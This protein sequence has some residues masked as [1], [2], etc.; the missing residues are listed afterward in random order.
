M[1]ALDSKVEKVFKKIL[2]DSNCAEDFLRQ[3]TMDEMYE[4]F[5]KMDSSISKEEFDE[6]ILDVLKN[7]EKIFNQEI[8]YEELK[9]VAG[10]NIGTRAVSGMLSVLALVPASGSFMAKTP[11]SNVGAHKPSSGIVSKIKS[12]ASYAAEAAKSGFVKTARWI[13]NN[14]KKSIAIAGSIAGIVLVGGIYKYRSSKL[15]EEK[16]KAET[17]RRAKEKAEAERKIQERL[18]AEEV[19]RKKQAEAEET[20]KAQQEADSKKREKAAVTP[21]A[22]SVDA[23]PAEQPK[24]LP[25]PPPKPLPVPPPKPLPVPPSKPLPVPPSKPLPMPEAAQSAE[26]LTSQA[27]YLS[28]EAKQVVG[29]KEKLQDQIRNSGEPTHKIKDAA[30]KVARDTREREERL[31]QLEV[32]AEKLMEEIK[33][34][35]AKNPRLSPG[36]SDVLKNL[37]DIFS[38]P[39]I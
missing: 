33:G 23:K 38:K 3:K 21:G 24:P 30:E 15:S 2:A 36:M 39:I 11:E 7:S 18:K 14:P 28:E 31:K 35:I 34:L 20:K 29:E 17:D 8:S 6:F 37:G 19:E 5:L 1:K 16:H 25:V 12:A 13:K 22:Q 26:I 10:G 27:K 32:R 4:F 9:D